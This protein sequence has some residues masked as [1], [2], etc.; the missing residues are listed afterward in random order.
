MLS[1]AEFTD[2]FDRVADLSGKQVY[3]E[4]GTSDPDADPQHPVD[5]TPLRI[6]TQLGAV[7][8]AEN[9]DYGRKAILLRL[10]DAPD[11]NRIYLDPAWIT[12]V[13]GHGGAIK[14]WFHDAFYLGLTG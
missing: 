14:I 4:I 7:E 3:I 12:R 5:T 13:E 9:L 10:Q 8:D 1:D 6:H 2:L 11:S